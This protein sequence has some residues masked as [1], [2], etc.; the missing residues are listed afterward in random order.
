MPNEI[1]SPTQ[2]KELLLDFRQIELKDISNQS[3]VPFPTLVKIRQGTTRDP[4]IDT[5]RKLYAAP[6]VVKRIAE[7]KRIVRQKNSPQ[8]EHATQEA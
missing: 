3:G 2:V 4:G 8:A 1:P 5:V 7:K 6:L